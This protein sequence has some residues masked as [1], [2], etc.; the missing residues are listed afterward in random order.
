MEGKVSRTDEGHVVRF[1]RRLNHP[2]EHVW[3]SITRPDRIVDWLTAEADMELTEGG[4]L[5]LRWSNGD[6]VTGSFVKVNP[7]VELEYTW[8]EPAAGRSSVRW[9]L[10]EDR[11]GCRLVLTHTFRH[12]DPGEIPNF[13]A[14]WHVHLDVLEAV[15]Q[16][17]RS[18]YPWDR[19]KELRKKYASG[20]NDEQVSRSGSEA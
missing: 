7:P 1:E 9:E 8:N 20:L 4:K 18:D 6:V 5:E 17:R 10:Q 16:D 12:S 11:G 19:V 15:L 14:G 13:L 2:V 3:A